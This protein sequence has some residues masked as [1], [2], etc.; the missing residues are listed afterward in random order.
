MILRNLRAVACAVVLC[1]LTLL[2]TSSFAQTYGRFLDPLPPGIWQNAAGN[3]P[4]TPFQFDRNVMAV[5][6]INGGM[7]QVGTIRFDY[8]TYN[9]GGPNGRVG[10]GLEGGFFMANNFQ[11]KQGWNLGWVQIVRSTFSG[12]NDWNLPANQDGGWFPDATPQNPFYPFPDG[13]GLLDPAPPNPP[14]QP[15]VGQKI[16]GA[17]T[18]YPN[19]FTVMGN[20]IWRA[21]LGLV[22]KNKTPDASGS[23][24]M[25]VIGTFLWGFDVTGAPNPG[26]SPDFPAFWGAPTQNFLNILNTYYSGN[27]V[28]GSGG[29]NQVTGERH[30]FVYNTNVFIPTPATLA[31][32]GLGGLVAARRRRAA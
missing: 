9:A 15:T 27:P 1:T 29:Q 20:Q 19:R 26:V 32:I 17:F 12:N 25:R 18:D 7:A 16:R 5:D 24:E 21:E 31:L 2:A 28:G 6:K 8:D 13:N 14:G 4:A 11:L 30:H 10:A 22:A 23:H 3:N